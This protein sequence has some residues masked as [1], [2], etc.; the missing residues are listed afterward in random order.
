MKDFQ[1]TMILLVVTIFWF[2]KPVPYSPSY[3]P[4]RNQNFIEQSSNTVIS[5]RAG[6][7]SSAFIP[8]KTNSQ[9]SN[10]ST[11]AQND[12]KKIILVRDTNRNGS[13]F[14]EGFSPPLPKRTGNKSAMG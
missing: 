6:G 5:Y 12:E 13:F 2:C 8:G 7:S 10:K 14:T 4:Y 9:S 11:S 1:R 3:S